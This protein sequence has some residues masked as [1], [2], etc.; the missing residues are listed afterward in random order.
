MDKG[1]PRYRDGIEDDIFMFSGAE[2]LVPFLSEVNPGEWQETELK[3]GDYKVKKYLTTTLFVKYNYQEQNGINILKSIT[4][5]ALSNGMLND[6]TDT[7]SSTHT[8]K[9]SI[10]CI[11]RSTL[12]YNK[13]PRE[14]V[15]SIFSKK[16]SF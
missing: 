7:R 13:Q 9:Y 5:A 8:E 11:K 1:L 3:L 15:K 6:R 12:F 14:E 2:D 10:H 16:M 4:L